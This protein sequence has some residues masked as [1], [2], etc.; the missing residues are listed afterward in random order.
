MY[1]RLEGVVAIVDA[2]GTSAASN[3]DAA[4]D[5]LERRDRL[6]GQTQEMFRDTSSDMI[7]EL[8][9]KRFPASDEELL[10][11]LSPEILTIGDTFVLHWPYPTYKPVAHMASIYWLGFLIAFSIPFGIKLR[12][13][14]ASGTY[15]REEGKTLIGPAVSQAAGWY[16]KHD[17]IGVVVEPNFGMLFSIEA[18][19]K[20][21]LPLASPPILI[22]YDVPIKPSGTLRMWTVGWPTFHHVACRPQVLEGTGS[23]SKREVFLKG[24]FQHGG[25]PLG[26]ERKYAETVRFFDHCS[27]LIDDEQ[28]ESMLGEV[29]SHV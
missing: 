17:M 4:V 28:L 2:L 5:F 9:A 20:T 12:G 14:I 19:R 27:S 11:L 22:D 21:G 13:A 16:E 24:L 25:I 7:R 6:F 3:S 18:Q 1:Q 10:G 26:T 29:S 8:A 23:L 15:V